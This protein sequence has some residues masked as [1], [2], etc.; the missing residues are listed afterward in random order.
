MPTM[1]KLW[2]SALIDIYDEK[3]S[4]QV[5][6]KYE[7]LKNATFWVP[8]LQSWDV[9]LLGGNFEV[10]KECNKSYG[11]AVSQQIRNLLFRNSSF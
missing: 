5:S 6:M 9:T 2:S 11:S 10:F 1:L 8:E 3:N 7:F 4:P